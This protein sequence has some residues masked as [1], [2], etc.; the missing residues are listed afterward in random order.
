MLNADGARSICSIE[1]FASSLR[2]LVLGTFFSQLGD[3]EIASA[4]N[5]VKLVVSETHHVT[6]VAPFAASLRELDAQQSGIHQTE[7]GGGGLE[8]AVQLVRLASNRD[9][10]DFRR[11]PQLFELDA[12]GLDDRAVASIASPSLISLHLRPHQEMLTTLAPVARTLRHLVV[13]GDPT[14]NNN[15]SLADDGVLTVTNLVTL[16]CSGYG[17]LTTLAPFATSL[18]QLRCEGNGCKLKGEAIGQLF[19]RI[20][21]SRSTVPLMVVNV[22]SVLLDSA[23]VK[24]KQHLVPF[25]FEKRLEGEWVRRKRSFQSKQDQSANNNKKSDACTLM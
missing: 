25:G 19:D 13:H 1:P 14:Y 23:L 16:D 4:A 15:S 22:G 17:N 7:G 12:I 24:P 5:L 2:E 10:R 18:E 11:F 20:A 21:T 6:T 3:E 9:I 8:D